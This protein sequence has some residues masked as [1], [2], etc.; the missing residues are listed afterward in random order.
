MPNFIT[1]IVHFK[2]NPKQTLALREA[3]QDDEYGMCGIDFEKIIPMPSGLFMGCIDSE[4]RARYGK[5]NW[6]DWSIANWGT[7]RN[8]FRFNDDPEAYSDNRIVFVTA[9]H[10]P[11]PV[12]QKLSEMYPDIT[13][14]H[15][16]ADDNV[17]HNCGE[18]TY[19]GGQIIDEYIPDYGRR[20]VDYACEVMGTTPA[21]HCLKLNEEGTAYVCAED[22][23]EDMEVKLGL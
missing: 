15:Q 22:E 12:L 21:D 10:V 7:G 3:V 19:K 16:W 6:L 4:V 2:G 14:R 9:N 23:D 20:A 13:M 18:H 1:N 8:A 5:N 11:H 17:G